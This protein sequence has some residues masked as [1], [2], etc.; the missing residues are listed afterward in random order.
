MTISPLWSKSPWRRLGLPRD[1]GRG[2][3]ALLIDIV[4]QGQ[5]AERTGT[6]D[7][8][9]GLDPRYIRRYDRPLAHLLAYMHPVVDDVRLGRIGDQGTA[10]GLLGFPEPAESLQQA[11]LLDFQRQA[12]GVR[13][14][15]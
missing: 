13:L 8:V 3:A 1:P 15:D 4:G 2:G 9:L 7:Q 5:N 12:C 11:A 10:Q 14:A 6:T